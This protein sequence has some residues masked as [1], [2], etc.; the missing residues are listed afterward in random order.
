MNFYAETHEK[1][2][3]IIMWTD[4]SLQPKN[5]G[6]WMGFATTTY[7]LVHQG[8]LKY[9]WVFVSLMIGTFLTGEWVTL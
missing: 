7:Q 6:L 8:Q 9:W 5:H 2:H 1:F 4:I 3:Q